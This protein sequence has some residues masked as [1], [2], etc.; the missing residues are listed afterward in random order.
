MLQVV[1]EAFEFI[2]RN[3]CLRVDAEFDGGFPF[4][5]AVSVILPGDDEALAVKSCG[6]I[7]SL[8]KEGAIEPAPEICNIQRV[9]VMTFN[10]HSG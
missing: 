9:E 10:V 4:G 5:P 2:E 7:G 1:S 6:M 3:F 8:H